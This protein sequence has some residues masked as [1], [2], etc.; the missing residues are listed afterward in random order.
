[1]CFCS[2]DNM[3]NEY[4]T[5]CERYDPDLDKWFEVKPM[6]TARRSPGVVVYR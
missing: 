6:I 2:Y 5:S 3:K 4:L 1:M